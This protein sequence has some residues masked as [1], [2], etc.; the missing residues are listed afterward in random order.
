MDAFMEDDVIHNAGDDSDDD[1]LVVE[2]ENGMLR[3]L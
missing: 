3:L 2:D 1:F